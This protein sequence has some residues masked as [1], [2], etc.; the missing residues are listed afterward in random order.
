MSSIHHPILQGLE[1]VAAFI[2]QQ[3]MEDLFSPR[4][5]YERGQEFCQ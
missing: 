2:A 1:Q 5:R 3:P 4:G